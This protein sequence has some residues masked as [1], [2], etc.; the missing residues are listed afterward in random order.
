MKEIFW[1]RPGKIAGRSG[2]N[3]VPWQLEE[4]RQ[5]GINSILSVNHGEDCHITL[6]EKLG[7]QYDCIPM[8]RN[9]PAI[10]GD[11]T[12]NLQKLPEALRFINEALASG[13]VLIHCRSG[14]DRTGLVMAAYLIANEQF[15]ARQAM[16]EVLSV[17]PIAFSAEGWTDFCFHVLCELE[18]L[19]K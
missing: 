16:D 2:P 15:S 5:A 9:A 17:R 1:L 6:I 14:K 3:L 19:I 12:H 13:P 18:K 8:S 4:I 7:F 11:T 10:P